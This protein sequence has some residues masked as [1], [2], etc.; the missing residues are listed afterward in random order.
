[1]QWPFPGA[2]GS[3]WGHQFW[4]F[5]THAESLMVLM[6]FTACTTKGRWNKR[7]ILIFC[8]SRKIGAES[9]AVLGRN[10]RFQQIRKDWKRS[11]LQGSGRRENITYH[12]YHRENMGAD[13]LPKHPVGLNIKIAFVQTQKAPLSFDMKWLLMTAFPVIVK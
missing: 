8:S 9:S 6:V 11:F 5:S 1:M 7:G 12:P 2:T 10:G 13:V 3:C 4:R